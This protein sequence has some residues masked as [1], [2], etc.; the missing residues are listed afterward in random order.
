MNEEILITNQVRGW[1]SDDLDKWVSFD[2]D[3]INKIVCLYAGMSYVDNEENKIVL[4]SKEN[5]YMNL[6][7]K[8]FLFSKKITSLSELKNCYGYDD[9][10]RCDEIWNNL[11]DSFPTKE[12]KLFDSLERTLG[13]CNVKKM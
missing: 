4:Y 12:E 3:T 5:K 1:T 7:Y 11:I 10:G 13:F 9:M 2:I 8:G 6:K